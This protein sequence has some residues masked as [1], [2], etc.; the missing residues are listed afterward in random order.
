MKQKVKK[1][2]IAKGQGFP[3]PPKN[4]CYNFVA[5]E[6]LVLLEGSWVGLIGMHREVW[7]SLQVST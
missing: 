1:S 5:K 7:F 4:G 3:P 2:I 6:G